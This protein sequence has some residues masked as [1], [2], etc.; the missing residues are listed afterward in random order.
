M[1]VTPNVLKERDIL[2]C[3]KAI[4]PDSFAYTS[5]YDGCWL[6]RFYEMHGIDLFTSKVVTEKDLRLK[7]AQ[8]DVLPELMIMGNFIVERSGVVSLCRSLGIDV[9]HTED[10]FFPHYETMHV[11]PLGFCWESS[12]TRMTFRTC[13]DTQRQ[14]ARE[15]RMA[16]TKFKPAELHPGIT[17]PYVFWPLQLIEDRVNQWDL[18]LK[19][20]DG[21]LHHFR[22]SLPSQYQLVIKQHPRS[23]INTLA[24][25]E[26]LSRELPNTL[27]VKKHEDLKTLI[28]R[29][30]AVAG[31]NSSVLYE[32]RLMFNKPVYCYAR[33]WFTNHADLFMP[34][35]KA[36]RPRELNRF[37]LVE[38]NALLKDDRLTD[39]ADWFLYQMLVRQIAT[40]DEARLDGGRF[41][42]QV[43]RLGYAS[44]LQHG[45]ELFA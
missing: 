11:D 42:R 18:N 1:E 29:S 37:D 4:I 14:R 45:D 19:E 35:Y 2:G 30:N 27:F 10:G 36:H 34:V 31:A 28:A 32:A 22:A 26:K 8:F 15:A 16:W 3:R 25:I 21:L 7:I 6:M 17:E 23:D 20:W 41:K 12:L 13:H 43:R 44:Y 24:G 40:H 38:D 9:V 5:P 39:Y 33:G